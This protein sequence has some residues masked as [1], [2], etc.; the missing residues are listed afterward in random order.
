MPDF[1]IRDFQSITEAKIPVKGFT[2]IV[3]DSSA[4]KSACLRA[5]FAATHNR[6]KIGQ[7][8]HG[9]EFIEVKVR[10]EDDDRIL[11]VRRNQ[12]GSP[13]MKLGDKVFSKMARCVPQEVE[14]FNNFGTLDVGNDIYSLNFHE[15]FQKPLLLEYSQ[16]KVMEILSASK[17]LD[18]LQVVHYALS[19]KRE[20]NRGAF[21]TVEALVNENNAKL[22]MLK[23]DL[24][25]TESTFERVQEL[26]NHLQKIETTLTSLSSLQVLINKHKKIDQSCD[27]LT[28]V[29]AACH[30]VKLH[31]DRLASVQELSN[32]VKVLSKNESREKLLVSVIAGVGTVLSLTPLQKVDEFSRK[33]NSYK[34]IGHQIA[35][36][37]NIN[38]VCSDGVKLQAIQKHSTDFSI[39]ADSLKSLLGSMVVLENREKQLVDVVENHICPVCGSKVE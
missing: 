30:E 23:Y 31:S 20:Q 18:D 12:T 5:M 29:L 2:I 22:S 26:Y 34:S 14:E 21:K 28:D 38:R 36:H 8:Q 9:K 16:K 35:L 1:I 4:G 11:V 33:W 15:Q 27:I 32:H 39:K 3:G 24:S 7:V 25:Q 17:S 13:V 19:K 10:Y 6:F 37:E